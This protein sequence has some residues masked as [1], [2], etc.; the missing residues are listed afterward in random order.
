MSRFL[1][2]ILSAAM[3][4]APVGAAFAQNASGTQCQQGQQN[5]LGQR[6]DTPGQTGQ[7][8]S[9]SAASQQQSTQAAS[10]G[11]NGKSSSTTSAAANTSQSSQT[12]AAPKI[13]DSAS[14]KPRFT[15]P[16]SGKVAAAPKGR[17]YR[18]VNDR[19]VLVDSSTA[20]IVQIIGALSALS[21]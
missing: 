17:E 7:S 13:G 11:Q 6:C 10:H 9:K 20:R 5:R 14:G 12:A 1:S 3:L 18:V 19:V 16:A 8:G 15:P 21:K 2:T 4:T